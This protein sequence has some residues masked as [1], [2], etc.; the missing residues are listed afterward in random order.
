M[1][2]PH[3]HQH[4]C[5]WCSGILVMLD[6]YTAAHGYPPTMREI[7]AAIGLASTS[8]VARH[9]RY[10][11]EAGVVERQPAIARGLRLTESGRAQ[12]AEILW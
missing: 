7:G 12:I 4:T 9:L 11:V 2:P 6:G 1:R 3:H 8:N 10:L 5:T